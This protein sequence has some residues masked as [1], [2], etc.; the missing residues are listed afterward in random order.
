MFAVDTDLNREYNV[1]DDQLS[2]F[3]AGVVFEK[4]T[5]WLE[6]EVLNAILAS[7]PVADEERVSPTAMLRVESQP[8]RA[9]LP[10]IYCYVEARDVFRLQHIDD[11]EYGFGAR[12]RYGLHQKWQLMSLDVRND[13]TAPEVAHEG[14]V[15][16]GFG[17]TDVVPTPN[18]LQ[19]QYSWLGPNDRCHVAGL[20]R[21][22]D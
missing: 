3:P 16:C 14:F 13:G 22:L 20:R 17:T 10:P 11:P 12:D 8:V 2:A 18:E 9:D 21:R 15:W 7:E 5:D 19:L 4:I 1:T 6:R